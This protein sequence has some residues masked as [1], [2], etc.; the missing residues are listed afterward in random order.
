LTF[1]GSPGK[2]PPT[3][4]PEA[5]TD[6]FVVPHIQRSGIPGVACTRPADE[7]EP[8]CNIQ[9]IAVDPKAKV[10]MESTVTKIRAARSL[11]R[12]Y[13]LASATR[14]FS[15][16]QYWQCEAAGIPSHEGQN[17]SES[18]SSGNKGLHKVNKIRAHNK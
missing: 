11:D 16:L 1:H 15:S 4:A 17:A 5:V 14:E 2:L 7:R 10:Q 13:G 3:W 9:R 6:G 8:L 12:L 18:S